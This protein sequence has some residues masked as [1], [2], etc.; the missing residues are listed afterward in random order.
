VDYFVDIGEQVTVCS[1]YPDVFIDSGAKVEAFARN[2]IDVLGHYVNGKQNPHTTQWQDV[3]NS[4]GVN[5]PLEFDWHVKNRAMVERVWKQ[6]NGKPVL[7][8]HGGRLP[9][10]RTDGFGKELLP[11]R[12]AFDCA[13]DV[14]RDCFAVHIGS[15]DQVYPIA[16]DLDLRGKTSVSD[17]L[18]LAVS[19]DGM[20]AQCSFAVPMAECFDKPLL[21]IWAAHG[22]QSNMHPYVKAITPSKILCKATSQYVVDDWEKEQI[23][24]QAIAFRYIR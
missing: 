17:L 20:V 19:C 11:K 23:Q 6:A 13:L 9:M 4:A 3:C 2:G 22:M 16:C 12:E 21:A 10:N 24:E 1:D 18:D 15:V 5:V 7:L 8:V 14:L